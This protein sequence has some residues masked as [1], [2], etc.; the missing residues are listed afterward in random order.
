[1]VDLRQAV[2]ALNCQIYT[3]RRQG[4]NFAAFLAPSHVTQHV[5]YPQ[6]FI[7][8]TYSADYGT[9]KTGFQASGPAT[10]FTGDFAQLTRHA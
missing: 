7:F 5:L 9:I 2:Q 4:E 1:M 8:V 3:Y 6:K 10:I